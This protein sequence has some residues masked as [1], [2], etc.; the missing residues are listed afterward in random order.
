VA[1]GPEPVPRG[2]A[3]PPRARG[4]PLAVR[5]DDVP[6]RVHDREG[7]DGP[8]AVRARRAAERRV[9]V[10]VIRDHVLREAPRRR[11]GAGRRVRLPLRRR[12]GGGRGVPALL[13]LRAHL[14]Q[15]PPVPALRCARPRA[16]AGR[17]QEA[18][19]RPQRRLPGHLARRWLRSSFA[20]LINCRHRTS[21]CCRLVRI[22]VR[23][24]GSFLLFFLGPADD[25]LIYYVLWY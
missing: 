9:P 8:G 19:D 16:A 10:V 23:R 22:G 15:R 25:F 2:G 5:D 1:E 13:P 18:A 12:R 11:R 4:S 7:E 14:P 21:G 3:L 20:P 24:G 17:Q 6:Q